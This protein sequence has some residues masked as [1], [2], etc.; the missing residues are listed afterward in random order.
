MPGRAGAQWPARRP[1]CIA[2]ERGPSHAAQAGGVARPCRPTPRPL[3]GPGTPR[4]SESTRRCKAHAREL[5]PESSGVA[6]A[7]ARPCI[8]GESLAG[9][10]WDSWCRAAGVGP[11]QPAAALGEGPPD[12]GS[13]SRGWPPDQA[14]KRPGRR[15]L[16]RHRRSATRTAKG[17]QPSNATR[18]ATDASDAF[19]SD[20][21][22]ARPRLRNTGL[23]RKPKPRPH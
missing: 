22:P 15:S 17:S 5:E 13:G 19:L 6:Q 12:S 21:V 14:S 20:P 4:E 10:K 9:L 8:A 2:K 18:S 7:G 3:L 11:Q 1:T 23:C 16:Q